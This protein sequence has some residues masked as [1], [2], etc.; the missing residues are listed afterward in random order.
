[1][2][3]DCQARGDPGLA[4]SRMVGRVHLFS[5]SLRRRNKTTPAPAAAGMKHSA[6]P[7]TYANPRSIVATGSRKTKLGDQSFQSMAYSPHAAATS[8]QTNSSTDSRHRLAAP[9]S[10]P[11]TKNERTVIWP[12]VV[13]GNRYAANPFLS[14]EKTQSYCILGQKHGVD[15]SSAQGLDSHSNSRSDHKPRQAWLTP[16]P[17]SQSVI[18]NPKLKLLHLF[19]GFRFPHFNFSPA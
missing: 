16:T 11:I 8:A 19:S 14:M 10:T 1:M 15:P 6:T 5:R 2:M 3:T 4:C 9:I 17:A 18:P 12:S 7:T 13:M